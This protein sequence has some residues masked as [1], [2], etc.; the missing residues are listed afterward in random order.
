M[1]QE[2]KK[3][4]PKAWLRWQSLEGEQQDLPLEKDVFT[5][6]R[7]RDNNLVILDTRL[8]RRH[9]EIRFADECF[10]V[11]DLG[12]VNGTFLNGVRIETS[13]PLKD[14]DRIRTGSLEFVFALPEVEEKPVEEVKK[15]QTE[16][17]ERHT[18]VMLEPSKLPRLEISSGAQ[19][20]V[21]FDLV[22]EKTLVGRSGR[23]KQWDIML[24]DRAVSR[25]Q[26]QIIHEGE[27]FILV[28]LD[29]ANGTL[30]NDEI[31]GEPHLLKDGD[32]VTFGET[33][34]IFRSGEVGTL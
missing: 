24:P 28:D 10:Q 7:S 33:V 16:I 12:S 19:R 18:I 31:L 27:N 5:I 2:T 6:G 32:A 23:G 34:L 13:Q 1:S 26:A 30:L 3:T 14:G 17:P 22:K 8:S 29:S 4:L 9:A 11:A 15:E 21:T 20:G 25:P